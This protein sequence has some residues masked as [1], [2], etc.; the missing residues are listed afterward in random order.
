MKVDY[1]CEKALALTPGLRYLYPPM[2]NRMPPN[3]GFF[4]QYS[5]NPDYV[6]EIKKDG[7]R[8]MVFMANDEC[9]LWSRHGHPIKEQF[10]DTQLLSLRRLLVETF[11]DLQPLRFD[12]ELLHFRVQQEKG[13]I[14]LFDVMTLKGKDQTA[15]PMA[16]RRLPL[17]EM[18]L[19]DVANVGTSKERIFKPVP[20]GTGFQALYDHVLKDKTCEGLVLKNLKSKY[21]V[22]S[23]KTKFPLWMKVKRPDPHTLSCR[24]D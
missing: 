17:L 9:I 8:S 15:K 5:A 4:E 7:W 22:Y 12:G 10:G 2:P 11:A 6:A 13:R 20:V 14:Y 16:E 1:G 19:Q 3:N 21:P 23:T 18:K 24:D